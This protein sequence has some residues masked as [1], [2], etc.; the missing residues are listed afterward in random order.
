M[1][2]YHWG[3]LHKRSNDNRILM[4][5]PTDRTIRI[6]YTKSTALNHEKTKFL[7]FEVI[8]YPD[9]GRVCILRKRDTTKAAS[10]VFNQSRLH[11]SYATVLLLQQLLHSMD[12]SLLEK[13]MRKQDANLDTQTL[14]GLIR[15]EPTS[16]I[17]D[18]EF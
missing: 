9:T 11:L 14:A 16:E 5:E 10:H 2:D 15:V 18:E 7:I 1:R 13:I 3:V 17:E 4:A 8:E 6:L 12:V